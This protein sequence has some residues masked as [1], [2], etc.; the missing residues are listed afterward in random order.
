MSLLVVR[1]IRFWYL[2]LWHASTPHAR[3]RSNSARSTAD[4]G[5]SPCPPASCLSLH[6]TEV[7]DSRQAAVRR[8]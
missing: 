6:A 7:L 4:L 8:V 1:P 2:D 3:Q 5:L